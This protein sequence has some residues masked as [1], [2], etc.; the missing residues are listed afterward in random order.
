[1]EESVCAKGERRLDLVRCGLS[2]RLITAPKT[3]FIAIRALLDLADL[4]VRHYSLSELFHE[5]A[6]RL[7]KVAEFQLLHFGLHDPKENVMRRHLWEGEGPVVPE[8]VSLA[9][10]AS[11]Y[12]WQNQTSLLIRDLHEDQ[13]FPQG[14]GL[15]REKGFRT[16]YVFPLTTAQSRLGALGVGSRKADA[17]GQQDLELL[18]R[19]AELVAIAVETALTRRHFR[20]MP[21]RSWKV[22]IRVEFSCCARGR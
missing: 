18:L 2:T 15:L 8:A 14:F 17:Y 21:P 1:L 12:V 5:I 20:R 6:V 10:S 11:G 16:Y 4:M 22:K 3:N 7:R 13:R 9:D 19:V